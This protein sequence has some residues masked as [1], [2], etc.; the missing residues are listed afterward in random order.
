MAVTAMDIDKIDRIKRAVKENFD[1]SPD[2]YQEFEDAYHFF[3]RLNSELIEIMDLTP[4]ARVLDV[5]CG[6]GASSIQIL[7]ALPS[8]KVWGL[9]NSPEMLNKARDNYGDSNR[10]V[11]VEGDAS[12][13]S[14]YFEEEFDAIIYSASIFLIPDYGKS[15]RQARSLLAENGQIG[16]TFMDGVYDSDG[17]NLFVTA[18]EI[19]K[20]GVSTKKP[21]RIEDL[22][23]FFSDTFPNSASFV[24]EF[25]LAEPVLR[26]FFSIPAMSAGLFPGFD[27]AER[28]GKVISLFDVIRDRNKL[29]RWILMTSRQ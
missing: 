13:L 9:D 17:A 6:T 7:N 5:G 15:L 21:V 19:G 10:I 11:F 29:F 1:A 20:V 4:N 24:K 26:E 28:V 18:N 23:S 25:Q 8:G 2:Y 3:R 27:Y 22:C 16:L 14:N 12:N